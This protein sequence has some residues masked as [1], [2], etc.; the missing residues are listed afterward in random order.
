MKIIPSL[1]LPILA[2]AA[3]LLPPSNADAS[4]RTDIIRLTNKLERSVEK[5]R[6]AFDAHYRGTRE[7]NSLIGC[8]KSLRGR[9]ANISQ[10]ACESFDSV[11]ALR[12]DVNSMEGT[13]Y[14]IHNYL[15]QVERG[16]RRMGGNTHQVHCELN[17]IARTLQQIDGLATLRV[18]RR[19]QRDSGPQF[20]PGQLNPLQHNS[21]YRHPHY[22]A[23]NRNLGN[24]V[25][26][27]QNSHSSHYSGQRPSYSQ[28]YDHEHE[29]E[30][31][32]YYYGN[33]GSSYSHRGHSYRQPSTSNQFN[34]HPN[35]Q[36]NRYGH[37]S[38]RNQNHRYSSGTNHSSNRNNAPVPPDPR[39]ILESLF[40]GLQQR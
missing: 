1:T 8:V 2:F 26:P 20:V 6:C 14:Q 22:G 28:R 13:V 11:R 5:L 34:R 18:E 10:L 19:V 3:F 33:R 32:Q 15:D 21:A 39:L 7:Y 30:D 23:G 37:Q 25:F 31:D 35:S 27:N 38:N 24:L 9:A 17:K 29:Y 40:R 36:P 12:R 4:A 16:G